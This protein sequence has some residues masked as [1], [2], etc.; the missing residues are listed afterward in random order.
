MLRTIGRSMILFLLAASAGGGAFW[1]HARNSTEG[2]LRRDL[3]VQRQ[4]AE[5]LRVVVGR[6]SAERRVADVMVTEQNESAGIVRTT[7]LFVEYAK[8]GTPLPGKHFTIEGKLAHIDAMVVKFDGKFV[9]DADPLRGRSIALFTRIYGETQNPADGFRIDE[10]GKVPDVYRGADASV[11]RFEQDLWNNFWKLADDPSYRESMGVRVA[12]GEAVWRS[13]E[14]G[15]LYTLT[16]ESNG[17]L[18]ISPERIK[19]IYQEALKK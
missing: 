3:D 9:Q 8:D 10:P 14:P 11:S 12:Q 1:L 19:G 17:G 18:N 16:L 13:F 5:Q 15:W 2:Q 6:L 7:L 4:R